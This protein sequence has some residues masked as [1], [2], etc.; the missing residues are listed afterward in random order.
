MA[1]KPQKITFDPSASFMEVEEQQQFVNDVDL[2]NVE[3]DPM[4]DVQNVPHQA[5]NQPVQ[6]VDVNN[7]QNQQPQQ[8]TYN[9][10]QQFQQALAESY[11]EPEVSYGEANKN[12]SRMT[13]ALDVFNSVDTRQSL[14]SENEEFAIGE[15]VKAIHKAIHILKEVDY[16]L[17]NGHAN[18][19]PKLKQVGSPIVK[20]LTAYVNKIEQLN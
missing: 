15:A 14:S 2:S 3:Y 13:G 10:A 11:Q 5:S 20:A 18:I 4:M 17:P 19:A 12:L 9:S 1:K 6:F 8:Q 16:W 7:L